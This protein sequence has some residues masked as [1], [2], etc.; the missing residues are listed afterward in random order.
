[1]SASFTDIEYVDGIRH[2]RRRMTEMFFNEC[3]HY[4]MSVYDAVFMRRDFRDDIFQQS[5]VKLWTEIET[6]RIFVGD[7]GAL[8]RYDRHG[9]LRELTCNLKSF[10]IDI[11]KNDYRC[12][13]RHDWLSIA[14]DFEDFAH[15]IEVATAISPD[16]D[17]V[18]LAEQVVA[19]CV[20]DMPPRCKEILTMFYYDGMSLDDILVA[21]GDK[22]SSKNGLKTGKHKCMESLKARVRDA[23]RE[24]HLRY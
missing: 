3:R 21:R 8:L 12:W 13:L 20:A 5:F 18:P 10:L 1:M 14:E 6:G 19:S 23:F 17:P 9:G 4:F 24:L 16:D 7:D 2:G 11:A 15:T 22:H